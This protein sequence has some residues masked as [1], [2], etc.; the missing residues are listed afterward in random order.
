M[1]SS[2]IKLCQDNK[3][4]AR[5]TW[6]LN[7]IDYMSML[8]KD[9]QQ[10]DHQ[11][12]NVSRTVSFQDNLDDQSTQ[13]LAPADTNFQL[14]GVTLDA[15]VKIYC[16]RVDS[17]HVNAFKVLG[18]LSRSGNDT[19]AASDDD[20]EL[21]DTA[22]NPEKRRNRSAKRT[23]R[24]TLETNLSNITSH[25]LETDLAVDPLFHKMSAA[26]DE[27]GAKGML[28]NNLPVGPQ[29]QILFDSSEFAEDLS[30]SSQPQV[31]NTESLD[32]QPY[33]ITD[34]L[35]AEGVDDTGSICSAFLR[36]YCAKK[37]LLSINESSSS[38]TLDSSTFPTEESAAHTRED[39]FD[40]HTGCDFD[41]DD[42]DLQNAGTLGMFPTQ[43]TTNDMPTGRDDDDM[44]LFSGDEHSRRH[45][46]CSNITIAMAAQRGGLDLVEAGLSLNSNSSYT[47]FDASSLSGWA[48]PQHWRFRA[49]TAASLDPSIGGSRGESRKTKRPR[50]KTALLLDFFSA[51]PT[52]DFAREF[53]PGKTRASNQL[54]AT[55]RGGFS[56]KKVTLP[57]DLHYSSRN[58]ASLFL[59]PGAVVKGKN[60][61]KNGG[62]E[63]TPSE[64]G[65]DWYDFDNEFD[66]DEIHSPGHN[67]PSDDGADDF[68]A[69]NR[70]SDGLGME[71][72]DEPTR[73]ERI[74]INYAKVAKKVDVR[75]L[76]TGLWSKLCGEKQGTSEE[77]LSISDERNAEHHDSEM[78]AGA[79]IREGASQSLQGIV[80]EMSSF[81]PSESLTDVSL[82]YVF[83]CLLHLANEKTLNIAQDREE[84]LADL[85]ITSE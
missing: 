54:S 24:S 56:E 38:A 70:S 41:Y 9:E 48:G 37:R 33:D 29:G 26:F 55:V 46:E 39:T 49:T 61:S 12:D 44:N 22:A 85:V 35:P 51:A 10:H 75:Q 15:G 18:G 32:P 30:T 14:A 80:S 31:E 13:S 74:D 76:K 65:E 2:T 66:Q 50:G 63:H 52:I 16:S 28:M 25:K 73:V 19:S 84:S 5:N 71:L 27:G 36:F 79:D 53:E 40:D 11:P 81:V 60:E 20:S 43:D 1:Y 45:S 82:P 57:D 83:I 21:N 47:F 72:V 17:V 68:M 67:G 34:L 69:S 62:G 8:V 23:G 7:L 42:S 78:K 58:L 59:K 4:N 64:I 77:T 3:I 6:T